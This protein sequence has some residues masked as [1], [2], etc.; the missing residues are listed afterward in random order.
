MLY[1]TTYL[2]IFD[3]HDSNFKKTGKLSGSIVSLFLA[4]VKKSLL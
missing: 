2:I 4:S 3:Q 1:V